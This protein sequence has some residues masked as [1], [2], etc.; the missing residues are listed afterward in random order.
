MTKDEWLQIQNKLSHPWGVPILRPA[1]A[2]LDLE[3][4]EY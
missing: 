1:Q 4:Q 2:P 3:Q